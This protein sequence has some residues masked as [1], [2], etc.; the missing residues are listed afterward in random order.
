MTVRFPGQWVVMEELLQ[1]LSRASQ[2][3]EELERRVSALEGLSRV[4]PGHPVP[5]VVER[6]RVNS[7]E[8]Y[9]LPEASGIFAVLGRA[10]L[11]IA[12]AYVIRALSE[13]GVLPQTFILAIGVV[14]AGGWLWWATWPRV[15]SRFASTAYAMTATLIFAPMLAEVTLRFRLIPNSVAAA[16]LVA[17]MLAAVGLSWRRDLLAVAWLGVATAAL[18]ATLLIFISRD[19]VPYLLVL[20]LAASISE[21]A[22]GGQRWR[23][24]RALVA[25]AVDVAMWTLIY[26]FSLPDSAR[27]DY[28]PVRASM[29]LALPVLLLVIYSVSLAY[30]TLW[31]RQSASV[32]EIVQ[33]TVCFGLTGL[34]CFWFGHAAGLLAFGIACWLLAV[35]VYT[36]TFVSFNR[37]ATRNY[38]LYAAWSVTLVISGSVLVLS[39]AF[40][41]SFLSIVAVASGWM[42]LRLQ[43]LL[44][45][46][47]SAVYLGT[48]ALLSGLAQWEVSCVGGTISSRPTWAACIVALSVLS[49]FGIVERWTGEQWNLKVL[50]SLVAL[51]AVSAVVAA[52]IFAVVKLAIRGELPNLSHVAVVRTLMLCLFALLLAY[53]GSRWRR[54]ELVWT[55]YG[56]LAFLTAKLLLEDIRHGQSG[57]IAISICL[58]AVALII[59]PRV[60][61]S[62]RPGKSAPPPTRLHETE[63]PL[64]HLQ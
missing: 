60:A 40:A 29:L 6:V 57:S 5:V 17:F 56:A 26:V 47:Q 23:S 36:A 50:K 58:Y 19:V 20:L 35:I 9:K 39:P 41:A 46:Y 61:R 45:V 1:A 38:R 13:S 21:V 10:L 7:E 44:P 37:G 53:A 34:S 62:V 51:L 2:R 32:F 48:A 31:A 15:A 12:G 18:L 8:N 30:R 42:G 54:V 63:E 59:V 14:Y 33:T 22:A 27:A 43:R 24:L 52:S 3:I 4:T 49:C 28:A 55:A 11:G 64:T 16:L 25:P